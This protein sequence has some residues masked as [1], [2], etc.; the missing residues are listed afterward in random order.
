MWRRVETGLSPSSQTESHGA[1]VHE[2]GDVFRI[3]DADNVIGARTGRIV[4]RDAGVLFFH[5]ARAGLLDEHICGQREDLAARGHDLA[6]DDVVQLDGAMDDLLLKYG[7]KSHT[8]GGC[9]DEL[10]LFRRVHCAFATERSTEDSKDDGCGGVHQPDQ[11][12]RD[13]DKDVH[14][15]SDGQGDALG[16]L[17][18]EGLGDQL[19]EQDLEIG[20]QEQRQMITAAL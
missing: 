6:N 20:D 14:G 11:G 17:Q 10:Q 15:A 4:D 2:P 3:D 18:S 13:T 16:T 9:G 1:Q 19:A 12:P 7:E 8:T 5:D